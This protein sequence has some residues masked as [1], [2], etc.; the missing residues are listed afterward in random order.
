MPR[1]V[2]GDFLRLGR[3]KAI[4]ASGM[5]GFGCARITIFRL[6]IIASRLEAMETIAVRLE[7]IACIITHKRYGWGF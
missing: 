7:A 3:A 4:H 1:Y 2:W 5:A 6:K